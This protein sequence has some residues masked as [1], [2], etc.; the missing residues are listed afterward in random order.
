MY[1]MDQIHIHFLIDRFGTLKFRND[2]TCIF[3]L[4]KISQYM[5]S[6]NYISPGIMRIFVS[7]DHLKKKNRQSN[8]RRVPPQIFYN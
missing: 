1:G 8:I 4:P 3:L 7:T 5:T 6:L 2:I